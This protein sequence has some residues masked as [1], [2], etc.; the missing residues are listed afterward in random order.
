MIIKLII[1]LH[2]LYKY[3]CIFL[4]QVNLND[5]EIKI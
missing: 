5:Y 1:N 4:I 2:F 3:S